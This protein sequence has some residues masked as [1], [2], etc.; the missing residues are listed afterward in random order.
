MERSTKMEPGKQSKSKSSKRSMNYNA[1]ILRKKPSNLDNN[2]SPYTS[3]T[4][5]YAMDSSVA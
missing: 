1:A 4:N 5:M 2:K 3:A